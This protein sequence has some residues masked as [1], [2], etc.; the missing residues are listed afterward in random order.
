[1]GT[2]GITE[3]LSRLALETAFEALPATVV[4]SA[5]MRVLD[6]LGVMVA[7]S[8]HPSTL[9]SLDVASHMGGHPTAGVVGHAH[10]T[11]SP[12][13]AFVNGVAAHALEFCDFTPR[14]YTHLS[15]CLVPGTLPVAEEVNASGKALLG[16][17]VCGFEVGARIGR[18]MAPHLFNQGW[19]PNAIT[20]ALGV[21]AAAARLYG[22]DLMQTRMA[23]GLAASQGSGLRKNVG[24]MGKAFHH[25]HGSRCGVFA[26]L[27]AQRGYKVD[28]DIVEGEGQGKGHE[29]FGLVDTFNGIGN[30]DLDKMIDALGEDWELDHNRTVVRL[31]PTSTP[32]QSP[33]DAM[34]DLARRHDLE[35]ERVSRIELDVTRECITIACYPDAPNSH[36]AKFCLR[37]MM[38]VALIDKV[39][40]IAQFADARVRQNDVQSLMSKVTVSVPED[41]ERHRGT[42]G[43]GGVSWGE[44]R[45]RV[46]LDDGT[47]LTTSRSHARGY[48][49][50]PATWEDLK[51][52]FLDCADGVLATSVSEEVI[53]LVRGLER[54]PRASDL[55]GLL[56]TGTQR[57]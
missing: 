46:F 22:M 17:F 25:G 26:A 47:T 33:I 52:K 37:Y 2:L 57:R 13:A 4:E 9:I 44:T 11:S 21:S 34:L 42:W 54:L 53:S 28:P 38:A 43:E 31:H 16:A 55:M 30:Y 27:L 48:P 49:Q 6:T 14:A 41:L 8:R 12:L 23:L 19:H 40:G 24:S 36:R 10:R 32:A 50:E 29:R 56:T 5:K 45:L 18:G 35:P 51:A 3:R 39:A 7:G 15:A 20:G 1:M